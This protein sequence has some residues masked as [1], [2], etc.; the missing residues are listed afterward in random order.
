MYN[1]LWH[2]PPPTSF[3]DFGQVDAAY[4]LNAALGFARANDTVTATNS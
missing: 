2:G 4:I 1:T 3:M